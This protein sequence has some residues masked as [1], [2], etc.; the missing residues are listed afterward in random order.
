MRIIV[1]MIEAMHIETLLKSTGWTQTQLAN[2]VGVKQATVSRWL[3]GQLP[4]PK[5]QE[6]LKALIIDPNAKLE[7]SET[8][9]HPTLGERDLP[10]YA[11]AEGGDGE[12]VIST[13]R[14]DLVP[15]P[16]FLG[17]VKDGYAVMITGE[18]MIPAFRPGELA[19]VNPRLPPMRDR[20]HI[21]TTAPDDGHFRASIKH[22][23]SWTDKDWKCEQY[24]PAKGKERVFTLPR[25]TW[26]KALRVVGKYEGG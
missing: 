14:I 21:F 9:A 16:W 22:L 7:K 23:I 2:R 4:D 1:N 15:R 18:S 24:N 12:I 8:A 6:A 26:I 10:V 13:E 5:Q 25:V 3:K 17:E 11:A 20:D 19:I